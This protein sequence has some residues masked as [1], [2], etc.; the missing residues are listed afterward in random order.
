MH[1]AINSQLEVVQ[2]LIE[3]VGMDANVYDAVSSLLLLLDSMN[4]ITLTV[5]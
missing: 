4:D 2:Y 3:V 5:L 1:A